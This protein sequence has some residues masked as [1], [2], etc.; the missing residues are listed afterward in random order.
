MSLEEVVITLAALFCSLCRAAVIEATLHSRFIERVQSIKID[1]WSGPLTN[2]YTR[3]NLLAHFVNVTRPGEP[4]VD[5]YSEMFCAGYRF[6]LR[7]TDI[8][9]WSY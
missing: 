6:Q 1:K 9:G 8:K 3:G 7:I 2:T 4:A 5:F